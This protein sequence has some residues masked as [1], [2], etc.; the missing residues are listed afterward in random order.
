MAFNFQK[1]SGLVKHPKKKNN[2]PKLVIGI[3]QVDNLGP[4]NDNTN[5]PTAETMA[6]I[7]ERVND[8]VNKLSGIILHLENR[9]SIIQR[10][11]LIGFQC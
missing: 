2:I 10:Y 11:E 5:L 9:L 7:N 8:I 3:N 4:W 1:L 6:I